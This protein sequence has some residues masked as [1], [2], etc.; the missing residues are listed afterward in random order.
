MSEATP[1]QQVTRPFTPSMKA[2]L[3]LLTKQQQQE[4]GKLIE[5]FGEELGVTD[6]TWSVDLQQRVFF[7]QPSG[8]Q[9][10]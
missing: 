8:P 2:A 9:A 6:G 7:Q 10:V 4:L 1:Q 3:D 5:T